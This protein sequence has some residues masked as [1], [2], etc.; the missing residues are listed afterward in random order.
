MT[1]CHYHCYSSPPHSHALC[2]TFSSSA[3]Q[4]LLENYKKILKTNQ[5]GR[6]ISLEDAEEDAQHA[7]FFDDDK[8][9]LWHD[10]KDRPCFRVLA[11]GLKF[12]W[13]SSSDYWQYPKKDFG[14]KGESITVAELRRICWFEVWGIMDNLQMLRTDTKC[15][16][17]LELKMKQEAYGWQVPVQCYFVTPFSDL[18]IDNKNFD[19]EIPKDNEWNRMILGNFTVPSHPT[20]DED[21]MIIF[22]LRQNE[23]RWKSGLVVR[24]LIIRAVDN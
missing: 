8:K 14:T 13:G 19:T 15:E 9:L 4:Q 6:L 20:I 21:D 12:S 2:N 16:V 1:Y 17:S 10:N 3:D 18:K 11:E 24:S 22:L 23:G 7:V 5:L